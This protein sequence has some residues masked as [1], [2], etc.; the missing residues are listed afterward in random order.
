MEYGHCVYF[1]DRV[2]VGVNSI[3]R[4][5][6]A[7]RKLPIEIKIHHNVISHLYNPLPFTQWMQIEFGIIEVLC[8]FESHEFSDRI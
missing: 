6:T 8:A 1:S 2:E 3:K 5:V 4:K 7:L